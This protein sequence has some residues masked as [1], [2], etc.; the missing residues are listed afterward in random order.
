M[1]TLRPVVTIAAL[2]AL[3]GCGDSGSGPTFGDDH[4]R[5]YLERNGDR[6]QAM[7]DAGHPAAVRFREI[8]DLELGGTDIYAFEAWYAAL[9]GRLTDDPRYC[10]FAVAR[11]DEFVGQELATISGGG[12]PR[13]ASDSYLEI[14]SF[15]GD[16]MLTYDWCFEQAS[17]GQKTQWLD[18]VAQAVWNVWHPEEATWGGNAMPWSGWSI[19]NPSNNYYYSFLRATMLF[20][21]GA[22]GEHADAEQYLGFFRDTKIGGQLVPTF[23]ADLD[24]GGSRE[25]TGYGVSMHRLWELYDLW[26]GST[27]EDLSGLT[28]HT[29]ASLLHILHAVVPTRDRVA[30]IGDHA[31]DSTAALFDYHRNYIQELAYLFS[32]DA[33]V[34]AAL[35]FL[36][37]CSVPEMDQPFMYVYDFLYAVDVEPGSMDGLGRAYFGP[38][39]GQLFAR[40]GWDTDAT[41]VNLIAG[42]YTE[43]HAHRDQGSFM[44]YKGGWLAYDPIVESTSGIRQE[45]ELHNLVRIE[46]ATQRADTT[47]EMVAIARGDTWLHA[48]ADLGAAYGDSEVVDSVQREL[49][50]LEPDAVVIFDRVSSSGEQTWQLSAPSRPVLAGAR[51]TIDGAAHDLR[52]ERLIPA[53]ATPTIFDWTSDGD[54]NGGFRLDVSQPGGNNQF[55]H[56]LSIDATVDSAVRSDADGRIGVE[57]T[58]ADGRSATVRFGASGVDGTL[59]IRDSGGSVLDSATLDEGVDSL[60]E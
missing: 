49:V 51:A 52:V 47:S 60:P 15:V 14:G 34:P 16:V 40:S 48:A 39:T 13:V 1:T 25:G 58:F 2:A 10:D 29:R 33:V 36:A 59:E 45:E 42:P 22:H 31:R 53:A 28:G 57:I 55:L 24:G 19:D 56:V 6:L 46:G 18:Y 32:G 41:F 21:L 35:G 9:I 50:F 26:E 38:G 12:M 23:E 17:D 11:I 5:I 43:S 54:F 30:P 20:G 27:G 8:V 44:I 3:A 37:S 4:P 7:L